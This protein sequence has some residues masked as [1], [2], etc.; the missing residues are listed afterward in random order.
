[1]SRNHMNHNHVNFG[2]SSRLDY[3]LQTYED[4]LREST[5]PL[6]YRLDTNR[7]HH[8]NQCLSVFGPRSSYMGNGVS[9][10]VG[11]Q[12]APSQDLVDVESILSNRNVPLSKSKAGS[13]NPIDVTK[14]KLQHARICDDFLD[15]SSSRL[16]D[17]SKNYR[18]I[19][20]NRF[21]DLP[22]NPQANI[23][24]PRAKN[25]TLEAKDNFRQK[26]PKV[27]NVDPALPREYKSKKPGCTRTQ[28]PQCPKYF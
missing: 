13:V 2:H 26:V 18:G 25:T 4:R 23:F 16:T 6:L 24:Y 21:Y 19:A 5:D 27:R 15:S 22:K 7:I 9:T 12:I 20:I 3:D 8:E 1:M 10:T 17:P 11:C 14:F 28:C